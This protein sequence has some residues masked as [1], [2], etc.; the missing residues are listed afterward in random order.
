MGQAA[1]GLAATVAALALAYDVV[2]A[3]FLW[4]DY[5]VVHNCSV[6]SQ[7]DRGLWPWTN[8]W[9]F[10]LASLVLLTLL[11]GIFIASPVTS[12]VEEAWRFICR[13]KP[14]LEVGP[15]AGRRPNGNTKESQDFLFLWNGCLDAATALL[16]GI[17][18]YWGYNELYVDRPWCRDRDIAFAETHLWRFGQFTLV[19]E[20]ILGALALAGCFFFWSLPFCFELVEGSVERQAKDEAAAFNGIPGWPA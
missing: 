15:K 18:A 9:M 11:V 14:G 1:T 2:G 19:L 20:C 17:F 16:L 5:R 12:S 10:I 3:Y 8:L 7:L 6:A 4:S 13:R